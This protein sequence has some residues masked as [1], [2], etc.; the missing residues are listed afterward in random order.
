[1]KRRKR[2]L[3]G[4]LVCFL[5]ITHIAVPDIRVQAAGF[6]TEGDYEY[7]IN[8][9]GESVTITG[10]KGVGGKVVIPSEIAGKKLTCIGGHYEELFEEEGAFAYC[11]KL[12]S[13]VIPD[14]VTSI[15]RNAFFD[16]SNLMDVVIPDSVVSIGINA[17]FDCSKLG[18]ATLPKG[19]ENIGEGAF[20]GCGSLKNVVIPKSVKN[21]GE[22]SFEACRNLSNLEVEDGNSNYDSREKCNAIIETKTNTLISGCKNTKIPQSVQGIGNNAFFGCAGLT[23]M[24]I[25]DSVVSIGDCAFVEC[26]SLKNVTLPKGLKNLEANVFD[27]C[28]SLKNVTLPKSVENIGKRAFSFSG[29]TEIFIPKSVTSIGSSAFVAC[30]GLAKIKVEKGNTKYD[31]RDNCNAIIETKSN[32]LIAGCKNTKIPKSVKKIGESA[33]LGCDG[34]TSVIIPDCITSIGA[35][36]YCGC[37][38]LTSVTIPD[39]VTKIGDSAFDMCGVDSF[40]EELI[41]YGGKNSAAEKYAKKN[42]IAFRV[43]QGTKNSITCKKKTYNVSYG[44]RPFKINAQSGSK[45]TY[46]SLNTKVAAVDMNSGKVTIKGTGVATIDIKAGTASVKIT[47]RVSPKKQKVKSIKPSKKKLIVKWEKDRTASGYQVQLS[48]SKSFQKISK[49]QQL[50]RNSYTFSKLKAGKKYYVRVRSYKK[51]G[52]SILYGAWS[53]PQRSGKVNR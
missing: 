49:K 7:S 38:N 51:S 15:G 42:N 29:L 17:F 12:T 52:K 48:T 5:M 8:G 46:Q 26:S 43:K 44:M 35:E 30:E 10:Y 14:S 6:L 36:A 25:P 40:D 4:L 24:I 31:S 23:S 11:E 22:S 16:C 20:C 3:T 1:M 37:S 13:V 41:I 33:F 45:L 50:S 39:S 21:I 32:T 9:D 28:K 47:I 19:L 18:E 34:L 53:S 2:V 27:G